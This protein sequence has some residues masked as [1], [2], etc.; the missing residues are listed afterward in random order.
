MNL[1][2]DEHLVATIEDSNHGYKNSFKID[3][4]Q[5]LSFELNI[6]TIMSTCQFKIELT[7]IEKRK[8][9]DFIFVAKIR[10]QTEKYA[11][12]IH[13]IAFFDTDTAISMAKPTVL[14][15]HL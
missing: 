10:I 1:L 11:K 13:V 3:M 14:P 6:L 2:P 15:S 4:V 5:D 8:P 7:D 12:P 9:W